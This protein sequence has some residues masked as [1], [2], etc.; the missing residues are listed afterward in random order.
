MPACFLCVYLTG[1]VA[2]SR[3]RSP[4]PWMYLAASFGVA[5]LAI[6]ALLPKREG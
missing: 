5:P 2:L 1:R 6:L 4:R 3:G